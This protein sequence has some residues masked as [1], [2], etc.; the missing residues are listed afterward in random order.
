M[1]VELKKAYDRFPREKICGVLR[2]C[3]VDGRLLLGVKLLYS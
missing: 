1:L 3:S 2:E